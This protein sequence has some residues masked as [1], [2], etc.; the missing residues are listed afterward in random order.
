LYRTDVTRSRRLAL[1]LLR[2]ENDARPD[3]SR[4]LFHD[5]R[6]TKKISREERV[7]D[8]SGF[9]IV[10]RITDA[11]HLVEVGIVIESFP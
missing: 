7:W 3:D 6:K 4:K 2:L 10:Y 1:L 11:R 8:A 5:P 9:R